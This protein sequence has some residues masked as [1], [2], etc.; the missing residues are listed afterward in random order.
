VHLDGVDAPARGDVEQLD[1]LVD[2]ARHDH[3]RGEVEGGRGNLALVTEQSA[4]ATGRRRKSEGLGVVGRKSSA[5][6]D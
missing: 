4:K 5:D 6:R 3:V 1:G 2:R